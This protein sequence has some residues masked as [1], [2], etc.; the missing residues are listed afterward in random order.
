MTSASRRDKPSG[1]AKL[2]ML[3]VLNRTSRHDYQR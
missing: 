2:G 3:P 1:R